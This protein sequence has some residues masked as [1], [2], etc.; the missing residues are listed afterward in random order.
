M[1]SDKYNLIDLL[2]DEDIADHLIANGVITVSC[3]ELKDKIEICKDQDY[4]DIVL[5]DGYSYDTAFIGL[6]HD[7]RAIYDYDLMVR[8]LMQTENI[9]EIAAIEWIDYNSIR[10]LSYAGEKGPVILYRFN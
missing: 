10:A 7:G 4:N 9:D 1:F 2:G 6:T 5:F 8:W 3:E